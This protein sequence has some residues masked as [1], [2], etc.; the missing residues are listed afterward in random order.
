MFLESKFYEEY[1]FFV[2][3]LVKTIHKKPSAIP[4]FVEKKIY[5]KKLFS[6]QFLIV[7]KK[8]KYF[9][10]VKDTIDGLPFLN[11]RISPVLSRNLRFK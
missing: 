9:E 7:K 4:I 3:L 11:N 6:P 10:N 1:F 2:Y 8:K 5:K